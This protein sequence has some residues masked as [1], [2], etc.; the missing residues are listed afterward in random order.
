MKPKLLDQLRISIRA[1]HYSYRT[2]ETYVGWCRKFILFHNKRHPKEMGAAEVSDYLNYLTIRR[3]VSASTQRQAMCAIVYFFRHVIGRDPG[4]FENLARPKKTKNVP[5]VLSQDE[6]ARLLVCMAG[7]YHLMGSLLYG[8]GLRLMECLRLR[9]KDVDF[10]NGIITVRDGKGHKDRVV[11]LPASVRPALEKH[12]GRVRRVHMTELGEGYGSVELPYALARKYPS[13]DRQWIW[14]YVFPAAKRSTCPRSGAIRRH[15]VYETSIQR[16]VR[17]ASRQAEIP[18][19]V[20]PHT[21][22]HSFATHLLENGYDIRTVQE[23]LGHKNV[24]TTMIY[25]H[26]VNVGRRVCSPLDVITGLGGTGALPDARIPPPANDK[27]AATRRN[28]YRR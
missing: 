10:A 25:T 23:L 18:K 27:P 15:H 16:A 22:R 24:A 17:D 3:N 6:T 5:A 1:R 20:S 12:L 9:V 14:Q 28:P 8:A 2:E 21:L 4:E 26:V 7:Q 13:A 19:R 11:P